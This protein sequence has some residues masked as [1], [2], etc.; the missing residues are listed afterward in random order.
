MDIT[1]YLNLFNN[2]AGRMDKKTLGSKQIKIAIG[3]FADSVFLKLYKLSWANPSQDPVLSESRI[4]F[5]IWINDKALKEHK[6]FYNIHAL[7]LRQLKGYTIA[8][9][10][11]ANAFR[12][13]FKPHEIHWPN[14]STLF[15]PHTL[16]EGWIYI[17]TDDL[18]AELELLTKQ[19]FEI[20][21]MMDTL[22][23]KYK[24]S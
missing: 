12:T 2:A 18:L 11:F 16:M 1:Y 19:F 22:L 3:V 7:K 15:A 21:S 4:F 6:I 5:S 9:R 14:V 10:D 20:D 8:S 13:K 17:K 23:K 24:K